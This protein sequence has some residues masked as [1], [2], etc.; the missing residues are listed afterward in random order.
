M[1]ARAKWDAWEEAG[2]SLP[3]GC[4]VVKASE[5]RYLNVVRKAMGAEEIKGD[6]PVM[7]NHSSLAS[8]GSISKCPAFKEGCP[9]KTTLTVEEMEKLMASIPASH[10][11]GN[12]YISD[13][14]KSTMSKI[15][16]MEKKSGEA[17]AGAK[18]QQ[19]ITSWSDRLGY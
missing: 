11:G 1:V 12:S 8:S 2:K 10:V 9:F 4:D 14:F 13:S 17:K 15:H 3:P 7:E 19:H 6:L 18:R 16:E 5:L